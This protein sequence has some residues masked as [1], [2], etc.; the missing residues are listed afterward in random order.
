MLAIPYERAVPVG[1]RGV[2]AAKDSGV[3]H[4]AQAV[5]EATLGEVLLGDD[6]LWQQLLHRLDSKPLPGLGATAG[7]EAEA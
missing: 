3:A 2:V 5:G 4:E 1:E 6:H 7:E